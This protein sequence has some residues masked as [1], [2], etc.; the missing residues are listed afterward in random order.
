MAF[1]LCATLATGAWLWRLLGLSA[2]IIVSFFR[3]RKFGPSSAFGPGFRILLAA[4]AM[5]LSLG[6]RRIAHKSSLQ[7]FW[8]APVPAASLCIAGANRT[9]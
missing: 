8:T 9:P 6:P 2:L 5:I 1:F 7:D 3:R 4:C